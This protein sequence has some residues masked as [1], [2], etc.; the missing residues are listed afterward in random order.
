MAEVQQTDSSPK[1]PA[2]AAA[3]AARTT[4]L[5]AADW[6]GF[7]RWCR[8]RDLPALPAAPATIAAYLAHGPARLSPGTLA[9]RLS[10]I[11]ARHRE[12]GLALPRPDPAIRNVLRQARQAAAPRRKPAP[13]SAQLAR[14]AAACPGD[15]AGR[16]D[17]ALLLL[18][19]A[20]LS[21]ADL[22][23]LDAEN[24]RFTA[25]GMELALRA[26]P[27]SDVPARTLAVSRGATLAACPVRALEDWLR[28]SDTQFGPVFRKV[29]RWG[30][31]EHARLGTDAVRRVL[32]RRTLRRAPPSP[33]ASGE[34]P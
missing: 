25:A 20:G 6:T 34:A 2:A 24:V 16:R 27:D 10:A 19:A 12:A 14:M 11:A 21:R 22:V 30:N 7:V 31:L 8:A 32:A 15:L 9:R 1:P 5:Y 4:R 3:L 23:G 13:P 26:R 28:S 29:D 17:R 33:P 18:A